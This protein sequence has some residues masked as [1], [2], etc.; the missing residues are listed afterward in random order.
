MKLNLPLKAAAIAAA[1]GALFP[2]PCARASSPQLVWNDEFDQA[3][4]SAPDPSRWIY[5]LGVGSP[6]G[7]GNDELESYTNSRNNSLIVSDP[8]ATDGKA[9]AI[10]AQSSNGLY[11]SARINTASTFSFKYG[12]LEARAKV[13]SGAGCWPAFWAL[14][15]NIDTAGWPACGEIDVMEWVGKMPGSVSGSL[16]ATGY[17]GGNALTATSVLANGASYSDGYHVFAADWYPDQI[18][19]SVDGVVYETRKQSTIPSG[20]SWPFAQNFFIIL[21]FAVG[22]DWPGPP[23]SSTVFPQDYRVDYVRV[24]SL[25]TTPP[26]SLVWAPS[27]PTQVAAASPAGAQVKVT[28]QPPFSTFGAAIT[29]YEV[30]R[31]GDAAFTQGLASWSVGS[32]STSYVDTAAAAGGTYY[33]RVLATSANGTSDPSAPVQAAASAPS[34]TSQPVRQTIAEGSTVVLTFGATGTPAPSYQWFL[35]AAALPSAI[36]ATLVISGASAANAGTYTC[37]ASN[38]SGTVTSDA[39]TL[40]VVNSA[41]AGRLIN[42]STRAEVGT[43]SAILIAGFVVGGQGASG[44]EPLLIRGAGPALAPLGVAGALADPQLQLFR[45]TTPVATNSGWGGDAQITST[46]AAVGAFAWGNGSSHDCAL[47]ASAPAGLYTAQVSGASTDTGVSLV[48]VYDAT[49][50]GT[51]TPSSLRLINLSARVLVGSG[52]NTPIAGFVIGGLTSKTVLVRASGPALIPFGV[53]GTLPDPQLQLHDTTSVLASNSGWGGRPEIASA[54]A[55]V[56]AF[57]WADPLSSDSALL[58]TLKPGAY[59]AQVSSASNAP[60]VALVEIYDVP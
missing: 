5:D 57:N 16:H 29:G 18:I 55:A 56:G 49:P 45:G 25:P 21:N 26:A 47:L 44:T 20:A 6:P 27:P 54:A 23:N 48:E 43:G 50:Q 36:S 17:S 32:P 60:G 12:R 51:S 7:W 8:A 34:A 11:T 31:A 39:A 10:R 3:E 46:A 24:Y 42:I 19:F 38:A 14:G 53:S 58:L 15:D 13:P 9:L 28:W 4:G 41:D 1:A 40:S 22:G 52:A 59:T 2:V 37:T 33:Y 30:Q 35:N